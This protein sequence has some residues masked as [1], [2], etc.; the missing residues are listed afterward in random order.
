MPET[1]PQEASSLLD[2]NDRRL[3]SL[4]SPDWA[5]QWP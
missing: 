4:P 1:F 5:S 2:L 3:Q